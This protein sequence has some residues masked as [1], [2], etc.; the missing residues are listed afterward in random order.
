[1]VHRGVND[2][3]GYF[4]TDSSTWVAEEKNVPNLAVL[5]NGDKSLV[6]TC[7]ALDQPESATPG[8]A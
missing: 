2:E 7:N 3:K 6:N 8:A 4:M 5:F 1:M